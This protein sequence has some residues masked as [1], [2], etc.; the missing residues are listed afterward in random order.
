MAQ[1]K[2]APWAAWVLEGAGVTV[3]VEGLEN[4]PEG[5][6]VIASNHQ[7]AFDIPI[8]MTC[9]DRHVAFIAKQE[10]LQ[11]PLVG[12]WMRE[13][14]CIALDR[15]SARG[16]I[17]TFKKAGEAL[18]RGQTIVIFPEGTRSAGGPMIPFKKGSLRV[19]HQAGVPLLPV[20]LNRAWQVK[21]SGS[22]VLHP[23]EVVVVVHSPI[24]VTDMG[25]AEQRQLLE[26]V[27]GIVASGL[28]PEEAK[29]EA[30]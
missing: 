6:V 15:S 20:T 19:V 22:M 28:L 29:S 24:D 9:L 25:K 30:G 23:T 21:R 1:E 7:G 3:K 11:I 13:I 18:G 26:R 12:A 14:G 8:L 27:H 17:E 16:A 5:P 10:L 4:I 2:S